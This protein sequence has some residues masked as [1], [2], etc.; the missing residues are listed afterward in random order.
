MLEEFGK[1][2]GQIAYRCP[3]IPLI[4]NVTGE[5]A[6]AGEICTP[7]YWVRHAPAPVRFGDAIGYLAG[8]SVTCYFEV[9]P[10]AVPSAQ[11]HDC[12]SGSGEP[13]GGPIAT[14]S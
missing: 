10:G 8:H 13:G 6:A 1:V 4:S 5:A 9:G 12:L 3:E 11:I 2:A 7:G 14:P